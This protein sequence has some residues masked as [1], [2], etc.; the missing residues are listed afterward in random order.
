MDLS[1]NSGPMELT[2]KFSEKFLPS[3][4]RWLEKNMPAM[5]TKYQFLCIAQGS[6][7]AQNENFSASHL[8]EIWILEYLP[9]KGG[10]VLRGNLKVLWA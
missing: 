9:Y 10:L 4:R 8:W 2:V 5:L 6:K 3:R 7:W 1:Q